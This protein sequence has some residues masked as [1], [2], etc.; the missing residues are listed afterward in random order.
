MI[1]GNLLLALAWTALNGQ[2]TLSSLLTGAFLGRI[3]LIVLAKGGVLPS[4]EVG[5]LERVLSLLGYLVWQ[6]VVANL[7]VARDVVSIQPRLRPGVIRLPLE[8]S[9]DR[10]IML[11]AAMINITPGSVAL[12]L[13]EDRSVMFIPVMDMDTPDE[14]R[15][16]IKE[17]FE[18]RLLG[19]RP[20]AQGDIHAA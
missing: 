13:S 7:R 18:R 6:I 9:T 11:L 2:F 12:D 8:I 14:V 19:L 16:E 4:A 5:R 15:R 17:G 10:E 1:L 3:V 20:V